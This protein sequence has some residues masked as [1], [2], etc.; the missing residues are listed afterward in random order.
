[1]ELQTQTW[2][3]FVSKPGPDDPRAPGGNTAHRDLYDWVADS[4]KGKTH[5]QY[6]TNTK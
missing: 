1:M 2:T 6:L 4:L 5:A 3:A